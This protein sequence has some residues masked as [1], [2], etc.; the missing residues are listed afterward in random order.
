MPSHNHS[1]TINQAGAHTHTYDGIDG[2][3]SGWAGGRYG[4]RDGNTTGMF[5]GNHTHG[6]ARMNSTGGGQPHDNMPPY[7][8]VMFI[9]KR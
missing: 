2:R 7:Y 5:G 3:G 4:T 8:V 9:M 1:V 6:N